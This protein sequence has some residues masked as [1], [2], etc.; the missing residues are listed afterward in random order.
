MD[1]MASGGGS[2]IGVRRQEQRIAFAT[3]P[4]GT[5]LAYAI[6]GRGYPFVRAP[7]WLTHLQ[8]DWEST[9]WHPWLTELGRH[10]TVLRYDDRGCG[11]SDRDVE[12]ISFEAWVE[13]LEVVVDAAGM[14]RF[15]LFGMSQGAP[16]AIAYAAR[17]P[18]RVSHLIILGGYLMGY[19]A[20]D[21]TEQQRQEVAAMRTLIRLAWGSD[22]PVF[23]RV[24]TSSFVPD[25]NEELLHA[26]DELMRLTTSPENAVRFDEVDDDLDV[27]QLAAEV[28]VP[29]L[30]MHVDDDHVVSFE[31]GRS[32]AAAI[33]GARF[34]PLHGRN[35]VLQ[36]TDDAWPRFFELVD[37]FVGAGRPATPRLPVASVRGALSRRELTVLDL[38]GLGY[39]NQ[40]IAAEL[41][42]SSRTVERHLSNVYVKLGL[43]GKAA[44][45]GAAARAVEMR[46]TDGG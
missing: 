31:S 9:I 43:S 36:P 37:A 18:E 29:T 3:T 7:H 4:D 12:D 34:V 41:N 46:L 42:L 5:R 35:H 1:R 15:A 44:R 38:V 10:F 2:P 30:V 24:F 23:R 16:V 14:Q 17:H 45:A 20:R 6:H 28:R 39:S 21:I 33:P 19:G 22:N 40:R 11:L 8:Y 26:Y 32:I 27:R 13:D 25:G